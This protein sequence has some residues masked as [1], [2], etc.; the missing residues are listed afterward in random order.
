M[1]SVRK[2]AASGSELIIVVSR[3]A[4]FASVGAPPPDGS[5]AERG[6]AFDAV[7]D[8]R[9]IREDLGFRPTFPRL[10]DA[11]AVGA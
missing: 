6:R 11:M 7:L 1:T 5:A 4:L 3:L 9:R 8:G 2:S 10:A